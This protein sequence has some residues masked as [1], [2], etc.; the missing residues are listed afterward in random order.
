MAVAWWCA[1]SYW[2][3]TPSSL[4]TDVALFFEKVGS[5]LDGFDEAVELCVVFKSDG[6]GLGAVGNGESPLRETVGL[7]GDNQ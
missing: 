6:N 7:S 2:V 5:P 1:R 4:G 3:S